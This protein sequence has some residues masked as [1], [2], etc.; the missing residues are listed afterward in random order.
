MLG[1]RGLQALA[2]L[3]AHPSIP[4]QKISTRTTLSLVLR[5][6]SPSKANETK[7]T[8]NIYDVSQ[9]ESVPGSPFQKRVFQQIR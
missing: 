9:A 6:P 8:L 3:E 1:R 5:P 2:E 7:I 4:Q